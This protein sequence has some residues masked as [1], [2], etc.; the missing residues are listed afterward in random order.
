VPEIGHGL[1]NLFRVESRLVGI[2]QQ[3][4]S[5]EVDAEVQLTDEKPDQRDHDEAG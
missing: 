2:G 5:L 4:S 3:G 1:L